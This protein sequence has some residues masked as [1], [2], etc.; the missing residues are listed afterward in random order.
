MT[1]DPKHQ[2]ETLVCV[3]RRTDS[4][5]FKVIDCCTQSPL[6][7]FDRR[8]NRRPREPCLARVEPVFPLQY[9]RLRGDTC[10]LCP[11]RSNEVRM[12]ERDLRNAVAA[13]GRS[14]ECQRL[15]DVR[16]RSLKVR[17]V[18]RAGPEAFL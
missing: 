4:P 1:R 2:P 17:T 12:M 9:E 5:G 6:L 15:C 11:D 13:G 18:P 14:P 10:Q 3:H 16:K 8:V 7:R